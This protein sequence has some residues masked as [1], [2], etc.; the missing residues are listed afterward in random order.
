[1]GHN[2]G[3]VDEINLDVN[4]NSLNFGNLIFIENV[5]PRKTVDEVYSP[6]TSISPRWKRTEDNNLVAD[7]EED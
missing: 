1:M 6:F 7:F 5:D 3:R 2:S 4:D